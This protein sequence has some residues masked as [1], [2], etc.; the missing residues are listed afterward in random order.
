MY[1]QRK[2]NY[3]AH[4]IRQSHGLLDKTPSAIL[5]QRLPQALPAGVDPSQTLDL[6][7]RVAR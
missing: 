1:Q 4:R 7:L 6:W 3:A 2:E 5:G